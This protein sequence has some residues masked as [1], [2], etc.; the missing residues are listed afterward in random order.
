MGK[1][2]LK[3]TFLEKTQSH[4]LVSAMLDVERLFFIQ[5]MRE[6]REEGADVDSPE[7]HCSSFQL[8]LF[9]ESLQ[10]LLY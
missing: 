4:S 8:A 7:K 3:S 9:A 2:L 1:H 6:A 5:A 10:L